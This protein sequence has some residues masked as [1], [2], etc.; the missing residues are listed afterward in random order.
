MPGDRRACREAAALLP[1]LADG[2]DAGVD[3]RVLAHVHACLRCQA[4]LARYQRLLRLLAQL[5][6]HRP[7]APEGAVA[8]VLTALEERAQAG[9]LRSL[10]AGRRLALVAAVAVS[11]GAAAGTSV[12]AVAKVRGARRRAEPTR[13]AS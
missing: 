10:V 2:S 6:A 5:R 13:V 12:V 3:E 7:P 9:A 4:E 1:A 11:V 8:Q